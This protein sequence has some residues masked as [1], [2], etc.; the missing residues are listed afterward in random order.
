MISLVV[1]VICHDRVTATLCCDVV[2][3]LPSETQTVPSKKC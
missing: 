3:T 1:S 2:T